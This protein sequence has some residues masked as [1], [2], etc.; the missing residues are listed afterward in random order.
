MKFFETLLH[1]TFFF[2]LCFR[3][4][5]VLTSIYVGEGSKICMGTVSYIGP[6]QSLADKLGQKKPKNEDFRRISIS[7]WVKAAR[8]ISAIAY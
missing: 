8:E 4:F 2:V 1:K 5:L 7:V 3:I 6:I